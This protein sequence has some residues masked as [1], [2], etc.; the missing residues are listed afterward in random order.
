MQIR[1]SML[2]EFL[3]KCC[4]TMNDNVTLFQPNFDILFSKT[5]F[6]TL[7][8]DILL[9]FN[10]FYGYKITFVNFFWCGHLNVFDPHAFVKQGY[11]KMWLKKKKKKK[12]YTFTAHSYTLLLCIHILVN[13][14]GAPP[15]PS[16][17]YGWLIIFYLLPVNHFLSTDLKNEISS[18]NS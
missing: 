7:K 15:L 13:P 10:A 11:V 3:H 12:R 18:L 1:I 16:M 4:V 2:F 5:L 8:V 6:E 14:S 9:T 17:K